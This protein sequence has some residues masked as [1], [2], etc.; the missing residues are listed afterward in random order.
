[1]PVT[2]T[3]WVTSVVFGMIL[4]WTLGRRGPERRAVFRAS[5]LTAAVGGLVWATGPAAGSEP[6]MAAVSMTLG[7]V[8]TALSTQLAGHRT[9]P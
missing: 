6:A 3:A 4:G 9:A 2:T 1:M 7:G 5:I 8:A